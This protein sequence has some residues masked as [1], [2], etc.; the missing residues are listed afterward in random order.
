MVLIDEIGKELF[1]YNKGVI[2]HISKVPCLLWVDDIMVGNTS[3]EEIQI[4]LNM[5]NEISRK[6]KFKF[7]MDKCKHLVVGTD[8][9]PDKFL[10]LGDMVL[11]KTDTYKYLG[12]MMNRIGNLTD[13]M[14]LLS[15]KMIV[16]TK[17]I[18]EITSGYAMKNVQMG[19]IK[20]LINNTIN[21][22]LGYGL[23]PFKIGITEMKMLQHKQCK[24]IREIMGINKYVSD[25]VLLSD[26]GIID[27]KWEIYKRK[28][29]FYK[30]LLQNKNHV[31]K[32]NKCGKL[33]LEE[34]RIE[35]KIWEKDIESIMKELGI[36]KKISSNQMIY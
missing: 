3:Y 21:P 18:I 10:K 11:E 7:G 33:L 14:T 19:T 9:Y 13:H 16:A 30:S 32:G 20:I 24:A 12:V 2:L 8:N 25:M 6:Y 1:E 28:V 17:K 23:E 26:L 36:K 35:N 4:M 5:I 22:I 34:A 29:L 31:E 15:Q 27:I